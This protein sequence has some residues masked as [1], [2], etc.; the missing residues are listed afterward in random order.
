MKRSAYF[1]PPAHYPSNDELAYPGNKIR[2]TVIANAGYDQI[3][4]EAE[5]KKE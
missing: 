4:A 3:T 1:S 5:L 2:Q